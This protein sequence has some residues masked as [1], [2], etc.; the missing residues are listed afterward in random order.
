MRGTEYVANPTRIPDAADPARTLPSV[1]VP[2]VGQLT[3]TA[4]TEPTEAVP[5]ATPAERR[6]IKA[7]RAR[8]ATFALR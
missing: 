5:A 8:L 2:H 4:P 3:S 6:R 7:M 1:T